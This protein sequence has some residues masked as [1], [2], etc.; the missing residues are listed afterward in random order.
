[1]KSTFFGMVPVLVLQSVY[2]IVNVNST[3]ETTYLA[4]S[5]QTI[6][7]PCDCNTTFAT[8]DFFAIGS[9]NDLH[10]W[11]TSFYI[12][13][14]RYTGNFSGVRLTGFVKDWELVSNF[15]RK[16]WWPISFRLCYIC[17]G[18]NAIPICNLCI[19]MQDFFSPAP[20]NWCSISYFELDQQV[21]EIFKVMS[22]CPSVKVDGYVD[23][24]GGS[25]FCLGQ[26]S[27]VHR[28]DASEKARL[29]I[30]KP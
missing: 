20:E 12:R 6:K 3:T 1:M 17:S 16:L 30:G 4:I 11:L 14:P 5:Q 25:R 8:F 2:L 7:I 29:H 9:F 13:I 24:S 22:S 27:N 28:T 15:M 23:P 19:L 10:L 18:S 21:G 26:L